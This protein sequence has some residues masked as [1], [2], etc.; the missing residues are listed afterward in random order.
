[1][2]YYFH[3]AA[4]NPYNFIQ[5]DATYAVRE[6]WRETGKLPRW[7]SSSLGKFGILGEL[8]MEEKFFNSI[9]PYIERELGFKGRPKNRFGFGI[10]QGGANVVHTVLKREGFFDAAVAI[11]PATGVMEPF[12]SPEKQKMYRVRTAASRVLLRLAIHF[13]PEEFFNEDYYYNHVD[14]LHLG[15]KYLSKNSTPLYIQTSSNDELGLQE[16]GQL[17]AMLA[18]TKG[19]PVMFEELKGGHCVLRPHKVADFFKDFQN[20]EIPLQLKMLGRTRR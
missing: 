14:A 6:R 10:S 7:V 18:R 15:Q 5:R 16:G 17:L 20:G 3:G 1:V 13:M 2:I 19:A 11:C 8:G 9:I 12:A 4:G